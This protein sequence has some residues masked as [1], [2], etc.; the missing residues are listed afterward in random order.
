MGSWDENGSRE[1]QL[2]ISAEMFLSFLLYFFY[3]CILWTLTYRI[4]FRSHVVYWHGV[5]IFDS[6]CGLKTLINIDH[7]NMQ[8]DAIYHAMWWSCLINKINGSCGSQWVRESICV[9]VWVWVRVRTCMCVYVFGLLL[10]RLGWYH[11][12]EIK[13]F[14]MQEPQ[15]FIVV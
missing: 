9:C 7:F 6:S 11:C 13:W 15:S 3:W 2:K 5:Q 4:S 10:S 1:L 8:C 14:V 12:Q